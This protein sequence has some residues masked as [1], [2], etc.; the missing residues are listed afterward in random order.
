MEY[1]TLSFLESRVIGALLC[2]RN[3]FD[4]SQCP[5][6]GVV[7]LRIGVNSDVVL[8]ERII[9]F[10]MRLYIFYNKSNMPAWQIR[11]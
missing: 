3:K 10:Q 9:G 2:M 6:C 5:Y 8:C 11:L 4:A 7:R 1:D